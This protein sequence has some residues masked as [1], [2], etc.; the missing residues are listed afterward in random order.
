M[1]LPSELL[2]L[3]DAPMFIDEKQVEAFYDAV[4]RPDYE[5]S[6]LTL[7]KSISTEAKIGLT[8][9]VGVALP[10]FGKAGIDGSVEGT[11]AGERGQ[12]RTL[13]QIT[14]PYRHLLAVALHYAGQQ[15]DSRLV[16][17]YPSDGQVTNGKG[18][19]LSID[20]LSRD[21]IEATPRALA[22]L[23]MPPGSRFIPAALELVGG[24]VRVLVD[25]MG[26][27]LAG[28]C[29]PLYPGSQAPDDKKDDYLQ[30]YHDNFDDRVALQ[31]VEETVRGSQVAWIDYN[32]SLNGVRRP[33]IHLH[34]AGR[35]QFDTG[36]F[37]YNFIV[38]GLNYGLRFVG[39][40]KSGPDM[41]VL[42]V[43]ER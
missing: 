13:T 5:G 41:N 17:A 6:T 1:Q 7:S 43:F 27:K 42:A 40:L 11:R 18:E 31:I 36:V 12:D 20:W 3:L 30:W 4:L 26:T 38:R 21:F 39:T 37:A 35:G 16:I 29:A 8:T 14:N 19:P 23:D 32:V 2:W 28:G 24:E 9:S 34:L 33:F 25:P 10:W 22:F 15:D